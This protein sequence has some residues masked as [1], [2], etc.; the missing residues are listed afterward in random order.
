MGIVV[1]LSRCAHG[2]PPSS[3][4]PRNT[5]IFPRNR[6]IALAAPRRAAPQTASGRICSGGARNASIPTAIEKNDHHGC[7][8]LRGTSLAIM[9]T[10]IAPHQRVAM[11]TGAAAARSVERVR[12]RVTVTAQEHQNWRNDRCDSA[13]LRV[14][15]SISHSG[16]GNACSS[17][18]MHGLLGNFHAVNVNYSRV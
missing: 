12:R 9:G 7:G 18:I 8:A 13:R 3:L 14:S 1:R 6:N 17:G 10:I 4:V 2:I 11:P 15:R 16:S 5:N